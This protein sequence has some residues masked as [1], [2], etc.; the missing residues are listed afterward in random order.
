MAFLPSPF[1]ENVCIYHSLSGGARGY[2]PQELCSM[3]PFRV[4]G[5]STCEHSDARPRGR[6]ARDTI[7]TSSFLAPAGSVL[8]YGISMS[9]PPPAGTIRPGA[10]PPI[11]IRVPPPPGTRNRGEL[12]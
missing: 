12:S 11:S 2:L 6:G 5:G 3:F 4:S 7:A 8:G 9:V 10:P 1:I